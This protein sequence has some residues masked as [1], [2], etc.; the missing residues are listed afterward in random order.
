MAGSDD[1]LFE[2]T[3]RRFV[4][5]A[6]GSLGIG[7]V[8][9]ASGHPGS[10]K[11][12]DIDGEGGH[13]FNLEGTWF[14]N[15][16]EVGYHSLGGTGRRGS[17]AARNGGDRTAELRTHGDIAILCFRASSEDDPGRR[18]AVLDISEFNDAEVVNEADAGPDQ[19]SLEEA[20][21]EVLGI[22][23][24][25][26]AEANGATDVKF[27]DDGEYAFIATQALYPGPIRDGSNGTTEARDPRS[28]PQAT[29]GVVAVDLTRPDDPRTVD[30]VTETF[31]TGVHNLFHHRIDGDD[32]VFAC[33]DAGLI[34]PDSGVYVLRFDREP[35]KL[36]LVNR[37]TADGNTARG[38]V[39]P[40]HGLSYV[41]D[42]EV[43]DDPRTGRPTA[44]VADW[45]RGMRVLDV[46]DP[47]DI[48]HVGQFDMHQSHF[49]APFP[50]VVETPDGGTKRVAV[51]SHEEPDE[52]FDGRLDANS[53][54][55]NTPHK[56]KTNPNSTGTVFLVDCDGIYPDDPNYE[57]TDGATQLGELD[58]WTWKNVDTGK[59]FDDEIEE[60]E[61]RGD[62]HAQILQN[63]FSFQLS[64]HN[65][66]VA[67]HEI[68]G[69]ETFVVHQGHYHGGVRYLEVRPGTEGGLTEIDSGTEGPEGRRK[70]RAIGFDPEIVDEFE[71]SKGEVQGVRV[72][73][74]D[75]EYPNAGKEFGWINNSTDWSLVDVGHARPT[76][77]ETGNLTPDFWSSVE[78]NGVTFSADRS[79]GA[80]AT[81]H[82]DIPLEPPRPPADVERADDAVVFT[83]GQTNQVTIEVSTLERDG[84]AAD[85]HVRDR[86]PDGY[87]VVGGDDHVIYPQGNRR[88]V[89]F[90][91]TVEPGD[92]RT[93]TYFVEVPE[94]AGGGT[95]GP[96]EIS[97]DGEEWVGAG[98]TTDTNV[99]TGVSQ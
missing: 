2:Q 39:G 22:I 72:E 17:R 84:E 99:S 18:M 34:S 64:P 78:H 23:R 83:A 9:A 37:W 42:I 57:E 54:I 6:A 61:D 71:P 32:Y 79:A 67:K 58:N 90:A 12:S 41:H 45:D 31:S 56:N 5:M 10:G 93:F 43:H 16:T 1:P 33:K 40:E 50:D 86:I 89:E 65:S 87:E 15:A 14:N 73:E 63:E 19:R 52:R 76:N 60:Y 88:A 59:G 92:S 94:D 13:P 8:G 20:E 97:G 74:L 25:F 44:Y 7:A 49:A 29:G 46:S 48:E 53:N 81:K 38:Q 62:R 91:V 24:N 11:G 85:L 80:F 35:G 27:S 26:N 28:T 47:T 68:D 95:F 69:E 98:E 55:Y 96:V 66:Q 4:R 21:F 36:T 82:D 51:A 75:E 30:S 3:R 70:E 77:E